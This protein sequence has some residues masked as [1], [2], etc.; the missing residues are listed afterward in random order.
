MGR[1]AGNG[2][3]YTFRL[4][5]E[6]TGKYDPDVELKLPSVTTVIGAVLAKPQLVGWAYRQ[7][8]D[9]VAGM[10][11]VLKDRDEDEQE[12][13]C[14]LL[15]DASIMDEYFKENKLRPDDVK[16]EAS[17]RGIR[18]HSYLE[19]LATM[20]FEEGIRTATENMNIRDGYARAISNWWV[21][22]HPKVVA[23]EVKLPSF[24]HGFMGTA[25]LVWYDHLGLLHCTDLKSRKADSAI[26]DSD[27]IQGGA[28]KIAYEEMYGETVDA[29]D[30]LLARDDGSVLFEPSPL[31]APDVFL[32]LLSIYK[33]LKG[34]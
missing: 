25:D 29:V 22:W 18:V 10:V 30:V 27:C 26:Y 19:K 11:T 6:S 7:T 24:K 21:A 15:S 31:Y 2:S 14:E 33:N 28:Y 17:R 9:A 20:P 16:Y 1:A 4:F 12:A 23:S 5:D 34:G 32:M 13:L 8:L 3:H